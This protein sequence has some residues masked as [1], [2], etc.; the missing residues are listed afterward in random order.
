MPKGY[1]RHSE[2]RVCTLAVSGVSAIRVR[3]ASFPC[4]SSMRRFG[5][6]CLALR[7]RHQSCQDMVVLQPAGAS[8]VQLSGRTAS[9]CRTVQVVSMLAAHMVAAVFPHS[10]AHQPSSQLLVAVCGHVVPACHSAGR[11]GHLL[12]PSRM[13]EAHSLRS[14]A[15][16]AQGR[17]RRRR[18]H[19]QRHLLAVSTWL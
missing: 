7:E 10:P 6:N 14:Q 5:R 9:C 4:L 8:T 3:T 13:S 12:R 16:E 17:C 2:W 15:A 19:H 18:L 11:A 1:R